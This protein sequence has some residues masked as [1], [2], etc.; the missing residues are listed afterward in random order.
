MTTHN[1]K[2]PAPGQA[3]EATAARPSMEDSTAE[4]IVDARTAGGNETSSKVSRADALTA[5]ER[6]VLEHTAGFLHATAATALRKLLAASPVERPA[7]APKPVVLEHVAVA[8]DGG[9]LRWMTGRK[10]RDCELYA[11]PDGCHAPFLY[12]APQ[13]APAPADERAALPQIP[14]LV[15]S[16]AWLTVCL[17][18]E[19]SRLDDTTHKALDEVEAQLC[20]VRALTNG[21]I[22]YEAMVTARPSSPNAAPELERALSETIDERDQMEEAGTRLANAVGEFLGVDVG[23]WSSANDPILA[24]IEALRDRVW[25]PNAAG[26]ERANLSQAVELASMT[27]MFH[28]A[29]HDLGLINEALGLDPDDGGAAPILDAI[30]EL[31]AQIAP[32]QAAEPVAIPAG[33]VLVRRTPTEADIELLGEKPPFDDDVYVADMWDLII[34][35]ASRPFPDA[36]AATD[37]NAV[38]AAPPPPAPA[39]APVG[40]TVDQREAIEFVIGWYEQCTI[41]DNPYRE[42]VAALRALLDGDKHA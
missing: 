14:D 27:R 36:P 12:V 31:K 39:S 5:D 16:M 40:L 7:A 6:E 8:E 2:C 38:Y 20:C 37:S 41:A 19:L 30:E 32:A 35:Q 33:Y 21:A 29:C 15:K 23:E 3:S 17:R 18:T 10:P 13:P 4:G 26:A 34:E 25:S 28:A 42:H 9:R 22:D 24:A 11:A 1:E